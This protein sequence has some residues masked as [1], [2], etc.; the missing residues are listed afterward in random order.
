MTTCVLQRRG[1]R[2][3]DLRASLSL[4]FFRLGARCAPLTHRGLSKWVTMPGNLIWFGL[5]FAISKRAYTFPPARSLDPRTVPR[6][7][8]D[9]PIPPLPVQYT[10]TLSSHR[11]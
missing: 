8:A 3:Y 6:T 11:A 7:R 4:P 2:V 9:P 5:H 1:H 10:P